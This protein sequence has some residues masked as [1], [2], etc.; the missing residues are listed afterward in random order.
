M[1]A[2]IRIL[3][4]GAIMVI[5][6]EF[7]FYP[8]SVKPDSWIV[9]PFYAFAVAIAVYF[10]A[11]FQ[12][13]GWPGII[14]ATGLMGL[15]IEGVAVPVIYEQ[16][17]FTLVWTSLAWHMLISFGFG[18]IG[19]RWLL[20][21][22]LGVLVPSMSVAGFLLGIWGGHFWSVSEE[23]TGGPYWAQLWGG[24]V[25]VVIGHLILDRVSARSMPASRVGEWATAILVLL[26]WA[27]AW[28]LPLF[29]ISLILPA[30]YALTLWCFLRAG[31]RPDRTPLIFA[32]R[33]A[34]ARYPWMLLLPLAAM[35]GYDVSFGQPWEVTAWWIMVTG[36]L[37]TLPWLWAHGVMLAG[38]DG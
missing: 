36:P 5:W 23:E 10:L 33:I 20:R 25:V 22:P 8:V 7:W 13:T 37:A 26:L 28:A 4:I 35:V 31:A 2:L 24:F 34:P 11:R 30:F 32:Q 21:Q 17:P 9:L 18:V 6:S 1:T 12:R 29:P 15:A 38:R 16:P 27:A 3:A 14:V 19:T